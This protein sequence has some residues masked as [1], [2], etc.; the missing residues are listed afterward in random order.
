LAVQVVFCWAQQAALWQVRPAR[1]SAGSS[2]IA[3]WPP[4][5]WHVPPRQTLPPQHWL[6]ALHAALAGTQQ[7]RRVASQ[8]PLAQSAGSSQTCP[9]RPGA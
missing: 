3:P 9:V 8:L 6:L 7:T 5:A 1:Q 2:Q 4:A